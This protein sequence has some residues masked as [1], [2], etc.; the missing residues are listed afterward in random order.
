MASVESLTPTVVTTIDQY[1]DLYEL[2]NELSSRV[3][4]DP[5]GVRANMGQFPPDA[6]PKAGGVGGAQRGDEGKGDEVNTL[7]DTALQSGEK[8]G[9]AAKVAGGGGTGHHF[10]PRGGPEDGISFSVLPAA[11]DERW[12]QVVGKRVLCRPDKVFAEINLMRQLGYDTSPEKIKID[13]AAFLSWQGYVELDKAEEQ[14][15]AGQGRTIGTTKSGVG[16]SASTYVARQGMKMGDLLLPKDELRPKVIEEVDRINRQLRALNSPAQFEPDEV[17]REFLEFGGQL[18]PYIQ[19]TFHLVREAMFSGNALIIELSQAFGLGRETGIPRS[20]ASVDTSFGPFTRGY[21]IHERR[22]GYRT[23]VAK[24]GE[25]AV[26]EHILYA[27]M[28]AAF[29]ETIYERTAQRGKPEEGVVSK[30]K[31]ALQW[32]QVPLI[33][34]AIETMGLNQL[35]FKKVDVLDQL[36]YIE[37]GISYIFPD[38]TETDIYNQDDPRMLDER[39]TMRTIRMQGWNRSTVGITRFEDMPREVHAL[40]AV[41]EKLFGIPVTAIGNGPHVDEKIKRPGYP[42]LR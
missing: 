37:I 42:Y 38:G 18:G 8:G 11:V 2:W 13:P 24:L 25:T 30:R 35:V 12:K 34:G 10:N 14:R 1:P 6:N 29:Q 20:L 27:P 5:A 3:L 21:Q 31:R 32:L 22:L 36:P 33:Q 15:R 26:G 41:L 40:I 39:T 19:D 7:M 16:P 28:P 23:G 17:L 9:V 4:D